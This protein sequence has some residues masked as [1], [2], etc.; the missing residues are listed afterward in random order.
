MM[1]RLQPRISPPLAASATMLVA[2]RIARAIDRY[3]V[4]WVILAW[5]A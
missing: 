5:P 3:R 2:C 1:S 4:Y